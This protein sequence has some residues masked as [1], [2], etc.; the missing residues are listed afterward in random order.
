MMATELEKHSMQ[1]GCRKIVS[2][3]HRTS[4]LCWSCGHKANVIEG[5]CEC[6]NQAVR[7]HEDQELMRLDQFIKDCIKGLKE[8]EYRYYTPNYIYWVKKSSLDDYINLE[9][10][11]KFE[12]YHYYIKKQRD[13]G[14][15]TRLPRF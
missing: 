1:L 3:N 15:I 2:K 7:K 6:C 5:K 4:K 14:T 11:D 9:K 10:S 12:K 8:P 13:D